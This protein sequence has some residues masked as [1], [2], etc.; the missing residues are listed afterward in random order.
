VTAVVDHD[1][2]SAR[3]TLALLRDGEAS[4]V[5]VVSACLDRVDAAEASLHAWA[6]LDPGLVLARAR[7]LDAVPAAER[8]PL[9]GLPVGVKDI[10]DT[11]D[12]PTACGSPIHAGRR[13]GRD[14]TAVARLRAAGAIVVG[15]TVTTEF[16]L[17]APPPT[18]NPHDLDRTPGGSSSGS[19]AT[20][21]AG[22]VPVA[23]GT[24]TAGS[25]VRP[26]AFCGLVGVKPTLGAVPTDGVLP[27]SRSLDTVGVL[28]RRV[29][30]AALLLGHLTGDPH[31]Y[32][33]DGHPRRVGF[34]RTP[35]WDAIAPEVRSTVE[36]GV[37]R[38]ARHL[39]VVEVDL[40]ASFDGLVGAQQVVMGVEA[41]HEL[42]HL[43]RDHEAQ[44]SERLRAY[45]DEA[46]TL[47]DRYDDA[48]AQRDRCLAELPAV[49]ADL[50]ALLAP[51]VLDVAPPA[52]ESTGDPLLCRAWTLLG[53]PAVA[54]P[55]L[56]GTG[57]LPL[58]LQV[59][60]DRGRDAAALRA[61][62]RVTY[63]L[64]EDG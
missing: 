39:D 41:V 63:L 29:D 23:L 35:E 54:V 1:A 9:H 56:T 34:A 37:E 21:A 59:V 44:L 20:V 57:G 42:G 28:A 36:G 50:D 53:T 19:A 32:L 12:Q 61:A 26:A 49:F 60:A 58:G 62:A 30:D 3:A 18:R 45:L 33:V 48:L 7:E 52:S 40:P 22:G 51:A 27:V 64:R 47:T 10:V 13:P 43:R 55:G 11:A 15:K 38:L 24:Q 4:C 8:G 5:E 25:V 17:F 14:A 16:A 2:P 46:A 6:H 31:S